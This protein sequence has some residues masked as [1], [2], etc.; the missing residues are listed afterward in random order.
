[1][2]DKDELDRQRFESL[3]SQAL[4]LP[5][6]VIKE[7]RLNAGY[8]H[9]FDSMSLLQPI[10]AWWKWYQLGLRDAEEKE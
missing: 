1:M 10:S 2:S 3:A 4:D 9:S 6:T 5:L 7:A 8:R